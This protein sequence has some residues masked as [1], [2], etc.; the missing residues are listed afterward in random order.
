MSNP[1]SPA[2]SCADAPAVTVPDTHAGAAKPSRKGPRRATAPAGAPATSLSSVPALLVVGADGTLVPA[3]A[4][5]QS[6]QESALAES[7]LSE[8]TLQESESPA[9]DGHSPD[10]DPPAL[11]EPESSYEPASEIEAV[12]ARP[13]ETNAVEEPASEDGAA[14]AQ[15][16]VTPNTV[17]SK[18]AGASADPSEE[19]ATV[20]ADAPGDDATQK[21][22]VDALEPEAVADET[23]AA[24]TAL[25][26]QPVTEAAVPLSRR[27]RRLAEQGPMTGAAVASPA[28]TAA[29]QALT[30]APVPE[31]GR[32]I[33]EPGAGQQ[34]QEQ[35]G[36]RRG[37]RRGKFASFARGLFFLL[38]ISL[39]VVGMGTVLT[40][41]DE[42]AVGPSQTEANR[43]RTWEQTTRLLAQASHLGGSVGSVTVQDIL[44]QT[45]VDLAVQAAALGDG[46]PASTTTPTATPAPPTLAQFTAALHASGEALL[47]NAM[48]ADYAMGRVFA[49]A[50]TS[51]LLQSQNLSTAVGT[52]PQPSQFLPARVDFPAAVGPTCKSTLE[53][54]PGATIDAALRAGAMGEQ[55]AVY[56]YQVATT[57]FAEPQ[58]SSSAT[59]LAGHKRKLQVLNAELELR[60]LPLATP[61]AGFGLDSSF[62]SAPAKALARLEGELSAIYGDLA[63]L[64]LAQ[65]SSAVTPTAGAASAEPAPSTPSQEPSN[66]S[67]LR[68]I[69]VAWL[70]DSAQKQAF[71]GGTVGALPGL[72]ATLPPSATATP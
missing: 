12:D 41:H 36:R 16:A 51:Q 33:A 7:P 3:P 27:E 4:P 62:T 14:D 9:P 21:P 53:P 61:V 70:L 19:T 57:R 46:L 38:V 58:F 52:T 39:V 31:S 23:E 60:C 50:G 40:G 71:W 47:S 56:A 65:S 5:V 28:A 15:A 1:H 6:A 10:A 25:A 34:P 64:S 13:A 37:Q 55:K 26:E 17:A 48:T 72:A 45:A 18:F 69:S 43:Q 24:D 66:P 67:N 54:R 32:I 30:A 44:S 22:A 42:A 49:A 59:L 2:D 68:E 29:A 20:P 63:A 35:P 11:R 8:P